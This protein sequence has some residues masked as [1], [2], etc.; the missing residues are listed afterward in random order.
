MT[1][2]AAAA[3]IGAVA[4]VGFAG[5]A[6]ASATIDLI[7]AGTGTNQIN[8]VNTSSAITLRV[9]LT[10]GP[11]G[12]QGAG[13]S[14]DYS[15]VLGTL[16]AIGYTST[17]G[18]PLPLTLGTTIDTGSRIENINSACIPTWPCTGLAAGR[19]HQLGTVTFHK[20]QLF[21]GTLEI[22]SDADGPTDGVLDLAGREISATTTF[23]SAFLC[24]GIAS[25]PTPAPTPTPSATPTLTPTPSP[26]GPASATIDLI[27]AD[28]GTNEIR[29]AEPSSSITLQV[30]LVAGPNGSAGGGISVDY[31]EVLGTLA[32]IGFRSTPGGPLPFTLGTTI[33][34]GSRIENINSVSLPPYVGTGLTTAG[35]THQLGTITFQA[36]QPVAGRLEIRSDAN[37]PTDGVLG[38]HGENLTPTTR[39]NSAYL[40]DELVEPCDL[41]I[42][43][44]ALRGGSPRLD[45]PGT[46][47]ITAKARIA[48]GTAVDGTT[49]DV[50]LRI[51]A[52]DAAT[53]VDS[54]TA[55]PI[56]LEI[57]KS[58]RGA[59]LELSVPTCTTGVI[60]FQATFFRPEP[61]GGV[62]QA[63]R[64]ITKS[65]N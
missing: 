60:A 41:V 30:I 65:C 9:I 36:S 29:N 51:D 62:C 48:K 55:G 8:D 1:V 54:V 58:G 39:F 14:V 56:R 12:S 21:N 42:E 52:I 7:W 19:S 32:A 27:W 53:V 49:T 13:V 25:C 4:L 2:L 34:T 11:N 63:T 50:M 5:A 18:G 28:T 6:N 44:N 31:S 22:R 38:L 35:Q 17:P 26:T 37:G 47:E 43:I 10:A 61:F 20:S 3:V 64:T 33:D 15:E 45:I 40:L 59:K 24:D 46:K 57:G 16:A 23:N